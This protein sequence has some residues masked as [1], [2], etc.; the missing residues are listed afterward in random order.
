MAKPV[1][2]IAQQRA[3]GLEIETVQRVIVEESSTDGGGSFE[4]R[5][6]MAAVECLKIGGERLRRFAARLGSG[7]IPH[8]APQNRRAASGLYRLFKQF[9][10]DILPLLR[11]SGFAHGCSTRGEVMAAI[12]APLDA[13]HAIPDGVGPSCA[14]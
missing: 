7:P 8:Q 6:R 3:F 9:G 12:V 14:L 11:L 10:I 1:E 2:H 4:Q 5:R 13:P